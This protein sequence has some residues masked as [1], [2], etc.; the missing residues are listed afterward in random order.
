MNMIRLSVDGM[1][2][3]GC[4]GSVERAIQAVPGVLRVR[5]DLASKAVEVEAAAT[6]TPAEVIA[7]VEN[8]GYEARLS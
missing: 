5:A 2:C 3:G 8:A 6:V 4:V 7:A 1:N